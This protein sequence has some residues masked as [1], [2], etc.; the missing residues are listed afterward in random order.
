MPYM[1]Y[2]KA[3]QAALDGS[4]IRRRAWREG[5]SAYYVG[6]GFVESAGDGYVLEHRPSFLDVRASDWL[7]KEDC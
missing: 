4:K 3:V 1:T 2:S 6:D 5:Y 7:V